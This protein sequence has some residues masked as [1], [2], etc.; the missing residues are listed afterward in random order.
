MHPAKTQTSLGIRPVWSK[1]SLSAWRKLGVLS[2]PLSALRRLWSDWADAPGWSESSLGAQ[3]FLLVF[4]W[5][6]SNCTDWISVNPRRIAS[7][8]ACFNF[9]TSRSL[10]LSKA[11][12]K[13]VQCFWSKIY[14]YFGIECYKDSFWIRFLLNWYVCIDGFAAHCFRRFISQCNRE[15]WESKF[16]Y[17]WESRFKYQWFHHLLLQSL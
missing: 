1:S 12:S 5:G 2:Y 7:L 16:K 14:F 17:R 11:G 3:S 15:R 10:V 8:W 9:F 13:V 6:S 4:S